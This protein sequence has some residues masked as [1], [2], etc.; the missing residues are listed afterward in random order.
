[1]PDIFESDTAQAATDKLDA[2]L[3]DVEEQAW[4]RARLLP[5]LGIDSGQP[6]S[7]EESFTAWSSFLAAIADEGAVIVI[8]DL[9]WA[10]LALL[11]FLSQLGERID[12]VPLLVICTTRPELYDRGSAWAEGGDS[13]TITLAPLSEQ[14][15]AELVSAL[16]PPSVS[17]QTR[18]AILERANGNPLFAEEMVRLLADTDLLE[19]GLADVPVPHSLQAL[20][21]ARLDTLPAGPQELASGRCGRR[22]RLLADGA[23]RDRRPRRRPSRARSAGVGAQGADPP[24]R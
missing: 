9:H 1:M 6:A 23:R 17:E 18:R 11:D 10:D 19:D 12:R 14:E 22:Q 16:I 13:E 4:L 2:V 15:T 5:L 20:I 24:F 3:P 8:E 7:R 21:A